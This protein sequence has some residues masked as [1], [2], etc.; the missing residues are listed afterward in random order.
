MPA[1]V[2]ELI[3]A[4]ATEFVANVPVGEGV[5]TLDG[6][7]VGHAMGGG[8]FVQLGSGE[9]GP[10]VGVGAEDGL[11][12]LRN[13]GNPTEQAKL[14]MKTIF[15]FTV[16][17]LVRGLVGLNVVVLATPESDPI[18]GEVGKTEGEVV[19]CIGKAKQLDC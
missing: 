4:V 16:G 6:A 8:V 12:E 7:S 5:G 18:G 3:P 10:T 2:A 9:G 15:W 17:L 11:V 19:C 13:P 1:T 14:L